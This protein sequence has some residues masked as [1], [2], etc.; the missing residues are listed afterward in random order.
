MRRFTHGRFCRGWRSCAICATLAIAG[1]TSAATAQNEYW[2]QRVSLFEILPVDNDDI[3]FLGNSITDGGEFAELFGNPAIK[4]RGISAD[5]ISGVD[6]RLS[7]IVEGQPRKI[8]LLIGVN[9]V[10][11]HLSASSIADSYGRLVRRI[12]EESPETILY[13]QSVMP[14]NNDFGRYKNLKGRENVIPEL[15]RRLEKIAAENG[16]TFIDLWPALADAGG[17]LRR[18]FTNDGLH[19]TGAGYRAWTDHIRRYVEE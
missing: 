15:N 11:H 3:V 1:C 12:R 18:E 10:S 16:A 7:Q 13:I 6:R 2:H 4:N 9:D 14:I 5:V 8:F 19:L 17:K